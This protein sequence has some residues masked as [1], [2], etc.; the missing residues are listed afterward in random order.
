M[1][2]IFVFFNPQKIIDATSEHSSIE[3]EKGDIVVIAIICSIGWF[4]ISLLSNIFLPI[5]FWIKNCSELFTLFI[6]EFI[7]LDCGAEN[8]LFTS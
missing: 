6:K 7:A 2:S 8:N 4:R 3:E 5:S 1:G